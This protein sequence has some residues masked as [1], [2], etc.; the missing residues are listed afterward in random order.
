MQH[1]EIKA[2]FEKSLTCVQHSFTPK[3]FKEL[4]GNVSKCA[5]ER[6]LGETKRAQNVGI[7]ISAC[8]CSVRQTHGLPCAHEIGEYIIQNRPIPLSSVHPFWVTLD[9]TKTPKSTSTELNPDSVLEILTNQFHNFDDT[10]K[11]Q[12]LKKLTEIVN[13]GST[14]IIEPQSKPAKKRGHQKVNVS[15]RR[16]PCAFEMVE[17]QHDS[18]S[19]RPCESIPSKDSAKTKKSKVLKVCK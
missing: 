9:M 4:R 13:P 11:A 6:I 2:S 18:Y 3:E 15:T 17:S 14:F 1:T 12:V 19:P 7:G 16:N 5:M 10:K 8:G